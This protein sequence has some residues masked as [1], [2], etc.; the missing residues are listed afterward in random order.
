MI[1]QALRDYMAHERGLELIR[2]GTEGVFNMRYEWDTE[3][4]ASNVL[5][6]GVTFDDALYVFRDTGGLITE[7]ADSDEERFAVLGMG[8]YGDL[9]VVIYTYRGEDVTRVISARKATRTERKT[10]EEEQ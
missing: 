4:A 7:D 6:H 3:K 8:A 5:K 2:N 1:N 10:Y 9:L